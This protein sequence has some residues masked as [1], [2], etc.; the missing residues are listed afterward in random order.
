[1]IKAIIMISE[2]LKLQRNVD[3]YVILHNNGSCSS[4]HNDDGTE[5]DKAHFLFTKTAFEVLGF[6]PEEIMN[7][8]RIVATVLKLGNLVFIPSSNIDGTE[9]CSISNDYGMFNKTISSPVMNMIMFK[10]FQNC[11]KFVN[12]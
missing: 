7:V 5:T 9:G 12:Y 1:M 3:N 8:L 10:C 2:S 11:M 4:L 6:C